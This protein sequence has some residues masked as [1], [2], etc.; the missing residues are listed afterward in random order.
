MNHKEN[1]GRT[2]LFEATENQNRKMIRLLAEELNADLNV[3]NIDG[4]TPMMRAAEMSEIEVLKSLRELG[5]DM[6][7]RNKCDEGKTLL[8]QVVSREKSEQQLK[9]LEFLGAGPRKPNPNMQDE[10]VFKS[11]PIHIAVL[12]NNMGAA[13]VL[14]KQLGAHLDVQDAQGRT[15]F[16]LAVELGNILGRALV[17]C[18]YKCTGGVGVQWA[19]VVGGSR[20][21]RSEANLAPQRPQSVSSSS[22]V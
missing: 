1:Q 8:H 5:A 22:R 21:N 3:P 13:D 10:S 7:E 6:N 18:T 20:A 4:K 9:V 11:Y 16:F 15:P 17:E 12:T 14:V 2:A 19:V